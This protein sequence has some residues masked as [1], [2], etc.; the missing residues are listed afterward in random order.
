MADD[1]RTL[2]DR[3]LAIA[4]DM[5]GGDPTPNEMALAF[6]KLS[7]TTR[8]LKLAEMDKDNA[9]RE[10][11]VAEAAKVQSYE[12]AMRAVHSTFTPAWEVGNE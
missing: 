1:E 10:F 7:L 4:A 9:G 6:A 8:S 5:T 3:E 12:T 2:L 11:S